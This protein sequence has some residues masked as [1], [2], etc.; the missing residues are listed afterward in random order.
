MLLEVRGNEV[1]ELR[2]VSSSTFYPLTITG[3]WQDLPP[4]LQINTVGL[5]AV[6]FWLRLLGAAGVKLR[7]VAAFSG[8]SEL[9]SLP[10]QSPTSTVVGMNVHEY[11]LSTAGDQN[12]I[13]S[14]PL[15]GVIRRVKLQIMGTSGTL[16]SAHV[17]AKEV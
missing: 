1:K 16:V 6:G 3:S 13:F 15:A 17:S 14:V 8:S 5:A 4:E 7:V 12:I 10:I 11:V 2:S 9:Y